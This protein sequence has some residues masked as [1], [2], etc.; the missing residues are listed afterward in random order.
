MVQDVRRATPFDRALGWF[1]LVLGRIARRLSG[2]SRRGQTP[3]TEATRR[4]DAI[5]PPDAPVEKTPRA[6]AEAVAHS[7]A[8]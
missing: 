6:E 2:G 5:P 4:G 1:L 3:G 7:I 8:R